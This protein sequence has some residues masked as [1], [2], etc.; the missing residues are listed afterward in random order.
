MMNRAILAGI[1][2]SLHPTRYL[3][4]TRLDEFL[5]RELGQTQRFPIIYKFDLI[6]YRQ[7]IVSQCC[8]RSYL[9]HSHH[10]HSSCQR[11]PCLCPSACCY[12]S[13][14]APCGVRSPLGLAVLFEGPWRTCAGRSCRLLRRIGRCGVSANS[15][16]I[17]MGPDGYLAL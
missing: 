16:N 6:V 14:N 15:N 11:T 13:S 7:L 1:F 2:I 9:S 4:N 10:A 3:V 12:P 17:R 8:L 5:V